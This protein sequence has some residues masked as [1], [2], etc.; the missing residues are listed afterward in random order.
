[1]TQ[2]LSMNKKW[3]NSLE[4]IIALNS[5]SMTDWCRTCKLLKHFLTLRMNN[6]YHR[7]DEEDKQEGH[8]Y[9]DYLGENSAQNHFFEGF[10]S[11]VKILSKVAGLKTKQ[12]LTIGNGR[13]VKNMYRRLSIVTLFST[14]SNFNLSRDCIITWRTH[15]LFELASRC[16]RHLAPSRQAQPDTMNPLATTGSDWRLWRVNKASATPSP[17][18]PHSRS[19]PV[20]TSYNICGI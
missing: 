10:E 3:I 8:S 15:V 17:P 1:M 5:T 11:P 16:I 13:S 12:I 20:E 6:D 19:Q 7:W 14:E 9:W 4:W 18:R 2:G